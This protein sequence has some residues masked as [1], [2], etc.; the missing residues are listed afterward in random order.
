MH[1]RRNLRIIFLYSEAG[2]CRSETA[3]GMNRNRQM[4]GAANG[5]N[6]YYQRWQMG[7]NLRR[8]VGHHRGI[9]NRRGLIHNQL[10]FKHYLSA[11]I[12]RGGRLRTTRP[13]ATCFGVTKLE[14]SEP[15]GFRAAKM[16]FA[17]L[18]GSCIL[19][20]S[21]AVVTTESAGSREVVV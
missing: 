10:I 8:P 9:A 2:E 17:A 20:I 14:I 6:E 3:R 18:I 5:N 21:D 19:A 15:Y 4:A 7:P 13:K 16:R 1:A 12:F 11:G